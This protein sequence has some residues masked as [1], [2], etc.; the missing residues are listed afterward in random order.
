MNTVTLPA[1]AKLNLTLDILGKRADGYHEL[2][3]VMQSVTLHDDVTVT[4][5]ECGGIVCRCGTLPGDESNLA[6]RAA[7]A[8][9]AGTGIAPCGLAI[10]VEKRIPTQAGMAGGSSDAA[11]VLHALRALL[12][13]G[14][15]VQELE[16]LGEQVGSDIPYCVRGGTALAEGRGEKLTTLKAAPRF[17]VVVCKPDFSVSTPVL[18]RRSDASEITDRP[19]TAGMLASGVAARVFNVF[20]AVLA[21]AE[22]EAV[23][24]IKETLLALGASAAAMTGSGPTVFGLF[25][26][27]HQAQLAYHHLKRSYQ[28]TFLS[29]FV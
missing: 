8:F 18:F 22:Q 21:Q 28:Q 20:E 17:H 7:K 16:T 24:S 5:T 25:T 4:L 12:A 26:G 27:L 29:E 23:F 19:D 6:V 14:M 1:Y 3:T 15:T 13:P 10:D 2:A 9:F 11:A